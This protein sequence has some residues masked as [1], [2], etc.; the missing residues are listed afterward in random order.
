MQSRVHFTP[1][2]RE[3]LL[4]TFYSSLEVSVSTLY[5]AEELLHSTVTS[6]LSF[7]MFT[8]FGSFT[9]SIPG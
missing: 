1:F 9:S 8:D 3:P 6:V 2:W 7:Q 4:E 5:G